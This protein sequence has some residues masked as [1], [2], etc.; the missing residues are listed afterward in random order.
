MK[1]GR[2]PETTCQG[3]SVLRKGLPQSLVPRPNGTKTP[4][5][6]SITTLSNGTPMAPKEQRELK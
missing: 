5:Q 1:P 3:S 4:S 6:S 2:Y